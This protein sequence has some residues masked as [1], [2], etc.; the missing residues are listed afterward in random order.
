MAYKTVRLAPP[1]PRTKR[2]LSF[3][4]AKCRAL[5]L[6]QATHRSDSPHRTTSAINRKNFPPPCPG[7]CGRGCAPVPNPTWGRGLSE[8][9]EFRSPNLRDRGKGA[10][11]G[12]RPGA[13]GFGSFCRNK[14]TSSRV[15][16]NPARIP[17]FCA[18]MRP[19]GVFNQQ[20]EVSC[21]DSKPSVWCP[22]PSASC[23]SVC[24]SFPNSIFRP[25]Y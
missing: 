23:S 14:R 7:A 9:S 24:T 15:G 17:P 2:P 5:G 18:T 10:P 22:S 1:H 25:C 6:P 11:L 20:R 3:P 13:H 4:Q 12:P 21:L 19:N 8:R 16:R